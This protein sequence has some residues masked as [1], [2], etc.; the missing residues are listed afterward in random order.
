[1]NSIHRALPPY[2]P[3]SRSR[4]ALR[5]L[6]SLGL[7]LA[8]GVVASAGPFVL[9]KIADTDT[10]VPFHGADTFTSLSGGS[11][12]GDGAVAFNGSWGQGQIERGVYVVSGGAITRVA[13]QTTTFPGTSEKYQGFSFNGMLPYE[14]DLL[15]FGAYQYSPIGPMRGAYA[16]SA[17]SL[18]KIVDRNDPVPD[19]PGALWWEI[20]TGAVG[21]FMSGGNMAFTNVQNLSDRAAYS[22]IGGLFATVAD[23]STLVPGGGGD[24][25]LSA[26]ARGI[27]SDGTVLFGGSVAGVGRQIY[28]RQGDVFTYITGPGVT[29]PGRSEPFAS[30]GGG[31]DGNMDID[32]G[33]VVFVG[34]GD[35]EVEIVGTETLLRRSSGIYMWSG[36]VLTKILDSD[37]PVPGMPG[38]TFQTLQSS[39]GF[40][41]PFHS[42]AY[43]DGHLVFLAFVD[44]DGDYS[45]D[46]EMPV[47]FT[48]V[49]GS[50]IPL[51]ARGDMLNGKLVWNVYV[52]SEPLR[53]GEIGFGVQYLGAG[54]ET[55]LARLGNGPAVPEPSS[56]ALLGLGLLG[57]M[58]ALRRSRTRA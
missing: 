23:S 45:T 36:G 55:Y 9:T 48:D 25:F 56:V 34:Y 35:I 5:V 2:R 16:W 37:D 54:A 51:I 47:L 20:N 42:I 31:A 1:M 41:D 3:G 27:D 53:N 52:D 58:G 33:D 21:P 12:N 50:L 30:F 49:G 13:D 28:T 24:T 19:A 57:L 14:G 43:E 32:D 44:P 18:T 7:V 8:L 11:P 6:L 39:G 26:A 29:M 40:M 15:A 22:Y 10:L 17:G 4:V 46:N 38:S